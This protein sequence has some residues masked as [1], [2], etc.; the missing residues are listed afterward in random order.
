[1]GLI[2]GILGPVYVGGANT[3]FSP[4][5]FL[6]HPMRWLAAIS[7][8]QA[9]I[10]GGPNF[11]YDLCARK[12]TEEQKASLDLSCWRL[13]FN[14]A[15]PV[16][17]ET[18][19]RFTR[20]FAPCG[21]KP[22]AYYPCYGLAEATLI[23]AGPQTGR[24][25]KFGCFQA[26]ALSQGK[27]V[28]CLGEALGDVTLEARNLV[29]CGNAW[30]GDEICI[31]NPE[32]L[33]PYP[34]VAGS[35]QSVGEIWLRGGSVAQGYWNKPVESE[36]TFQARLADGSPG[37]YLRTGDLGFFWEGQLFVAGRL[38]DI[39]IIDGLNHYPQ[40]I[41]LTVERCH[42]ALRPGCS[43]AFSVDVEGQERLVVT[44]E[45][46]GGKKLK[47][48]Q[49]GQAIETNPEGI[50]RLVRQAVSSEHELRVDD[51]VLLKA[52]SIAKTS[53]G[54]IQRHACKQGY[55]AGT[56]ERWSA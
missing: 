14:G 1:M 33:L 27:V 5:D 47:E 4:L 49:E 21:F 48:L 13:A 20:A 41:E 22:E 17:N 12:A 29:G 18:L 46:A 6:Q 24:P 19:D 23:A 38:K 25:V 26:Q 54:K 16:R 30:L 2:G 56:L 45:V 11:A 28:P 52:G 42:P 44:V 53:S 50:R 39:I 10:S 43:A 40:D 34:L 9:D 32:T 35:S 55:L 3:L 15:E 51:V 7:R 31:V 8:K 37:H 36:A